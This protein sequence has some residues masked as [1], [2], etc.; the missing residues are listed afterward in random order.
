MIDSNTKMTRRS[1]LGTV[2]TLTS[3]VLL[4]PRLLPAGEF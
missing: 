2:G 1:F 3:A 4:A